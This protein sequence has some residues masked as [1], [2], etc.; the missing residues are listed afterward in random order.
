[1]SKTVTFAVIAIIGFSDALSAKN[2]LPCKFLDS[3][4]ITDGERYDDG[5]IF[6]QG[7]Q[8][9]SKLYAEIDYITVETDDGPKNVHVAPHLRGCLCE[10]KGIKVSKVHLSLFFLQFFLS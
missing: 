6:Y 9:P 4:N 5:T 1:M 10:I 3:H 2:E 8:Y 7:V